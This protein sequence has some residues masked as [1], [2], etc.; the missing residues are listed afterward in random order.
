MMSYSRPSIMKKIA[1]FLLGA[2]ILLPVYSAEAQLSDGERKNI[3]R[4]LFQEG[5]KLQESGKPADIPAALAKFEAAQKNFSAPTN[6]LHIAECQAL[7]GHLIDSS[8]TY[9]NLA[10]MKVDPDKDPPIFLQAQQQGAAESTAVKGRIPTLKVDVQPDPKTLQNLQI[11]FNDKPMPPELIGVPH[12]FDPG[13]YRV[14]AYANGYLLREPSGD[15]IVKEKETKILT[16]ILAPVGGAAV[17][18]VPVGATV[19]QNTPPPVAGA[20][21]NTPPKDQ[22]PPVPPPPPP[23]ENSKGFLV[24][25]TGN[26]LAPF[27]AL[28]K[29]GGS[30]G[31]TVDMGQMFSSGG[32]IGLEGGVRLVKVLYLGLVGELGTFG[33]GSATSNIP[34]A[35]VSTSTY[36]LGVEAGI[37]TSPDKVAFFG[38]LG[39]GLRGLQQSITGVSSSQ[40]LAVGG[41]S[42][43]FSGFDVWG[44]VGVAIPIGSKIRIV[45]TAQLA[46]GTLHRSSS[47]V[48]SSGSTTSSSNVSLAGDAFNGFAGL[49]VSGFY[50]GNL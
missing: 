23:P 34:N 13:T 27:G 18:P 25:I 6:V 26:F 21:Q 14:A 15:V 16:I 32:T 29:P 20:D 5:V 49:G 8:E 24:G 3:A 41:Q 4:T 47:D 10:K 33:A 12:Q 22:P 38:R 46:L 19:A 39:L 37:L 43:N 44:K 42:A 1:A 31:E 9:N 45:P 50:A 11:T 36:L 7:L 35:T 30:V 28:P 48:V 17:A 40:S 2:S